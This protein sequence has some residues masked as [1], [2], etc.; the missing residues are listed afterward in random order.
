M[1]NGTNNHE[2]IPQMNTITQQELCDYIEEDDFLLKYGNPVII[3]CD[4][5]RQLV[6]MAIE[7]YERM[8]GQKV[9]I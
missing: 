1:K 8:T 3:K 7:Y 5:G 4:D 2:Y 6:C 9:E